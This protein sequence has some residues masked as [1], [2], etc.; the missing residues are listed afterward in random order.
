MNVC[1]D[2]IRRILVCIFVYFLTL[3][4][5]SNSQTLQESITKAIQ[6]NTEVAIMQKK[7]ELTG[8]SKLDAKTNFLPKISANY[9]D[10]TRRTE[11]ASLKDKLEEDTQGITLNQPLFN[12]FSSVAKVKQAKYSYGASKENLVQSKNEIAFRVAESYLNSYFLEQ[13]IELEAKNTEVLEQ[14]LILAKQSLDLQDIDYSKFTEISI[15]KNKA[16]LKENED[17]SKLEENK[18]KLQILTGQNMIS[19]L[20]KPT[21]PKLGGLSELEIQT[22]TRN[23][24]V[25]AQKLNVK[26]KSSGVIAEAGKFAPK[27]SL[28][29]KYEDQ[30]ASQFF[31]GRSVTN[32]LIYL[33]VE[34]PIFQSGTEYASL[35]KA[36]KEKQIA[37]LQEKL[38]SE[39]VQ[40]Q[41]KMEYQKFNSIDQSLESIQDIIIMSEKSLNLSKDRLK[42]QD[43]SRLDVLLQESELIEM[44]IQKLSLELTKQMSYFKIKEIINEIL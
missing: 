17:I 31:N 9:T 41:L 38:A 32:R 29:L 16:Q 35:S 33:N 14:S 19:N 30:K 8:V 25:K 12:G 44:Q 39:E 15:R 3:P 5:I 42:K 4:T 18:L 23:P 40:N 21:M 2:I 36:R 22:K 43:I 34:I 24:Q 28:Y 26:S 7:T 10:G 6:S 11:I 27:V 1:I 20:Q 37:Q 13:I